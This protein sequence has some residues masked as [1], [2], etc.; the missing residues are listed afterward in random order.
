MKKKRHK[1][2]HIIYIFFVLNNEKRKKKKRHEHNNLW[3]LMQQIK[4][5]LCQLLKSN[6]GH[7]TRIKAYYQNLRTVIPPF[8]LILRCWRALNI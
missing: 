3:D 2:E 6:H 4:G 1:I 8:F 7:V 5:T